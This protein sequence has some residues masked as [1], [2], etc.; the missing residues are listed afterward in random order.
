MGRCWQL[1]GMMWSV[2]TAVSVAHGP[3][4]MSQVL[5]YSCTPSADEGRLEDSAE[6]QVE[7]A[8]DPA[9]VHPY[10]EVHNPSFDYVPPA[11][12]SLFLTGEWMM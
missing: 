12:I 6:E 10:L 9:C 8:N 1:V 5:E 7:E 4:N 11:L 3:E 2:C